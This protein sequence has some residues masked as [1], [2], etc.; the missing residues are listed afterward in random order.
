MGTAGIFLPIL[1][2]V[3]LFLLTLA[4]YAKGS[5]RFERRFV[6]SKPIKNIWSRS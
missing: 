3:P 6:S 1:P 4:C 5:V 2:T